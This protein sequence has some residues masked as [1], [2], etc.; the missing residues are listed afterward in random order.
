VLR[1][2]CVADSKEV[3]GGWRDLHSQEL[4]FTEYYFDNK[5]QE[6]ENGIA[7]TSN[8]GEIRNA[9]KILVV[10]HQSNSF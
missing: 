5:A 4:H 8:R 2:I 1:G 6:D 9:C 3:T 10:K 7:Y